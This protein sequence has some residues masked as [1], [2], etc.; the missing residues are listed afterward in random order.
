VS[1]TNSNT[2]QKELNLKTRIVPATTT[3]IDY[4]MSLWPPHDSEDW[5]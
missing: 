3:M 4:V 1:A 5:K 2:K